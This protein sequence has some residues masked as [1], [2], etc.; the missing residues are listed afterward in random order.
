MS[1]F[2]RRRWQHDRLASIIAPPFFFS[3]IF[4]SFTSFKQWVL[5]NA[6]FGAD[7]L[8][9]MLDRALF[10]GIDPWRITHSLFPG[11]AGSLVFDTAY[12]LWF[13][14]LV[15][16]VLFS[17]MAPLKLRTQFLLSFSL[18]WVFLGTLLAYFLPGAGPCYYEVFHGGSDFA[19]LMA[20]IH[21]HDTA[22]QKAGAAG[23]LA[24]RGQEE[25]LTAFQTGELMIAGGISAMP[26]LHNAIAVLFACA[27][28]AV[29]RVVGVAM[30]LFA[31]IIW[32][33]SVHLGWH[34]AIDGL[35]GGGAAILIWRG[36]GSWATRLTAEPAIA[37]AG[38]PLSGSSQPAHP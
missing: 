20:Q 6:G 24:L 26:S 4:A 25:L 18:I 11:P 37:D 3:L 36:T 2:I 30:S 10:F 12:A 31:A 38:P 35:L 8:F 22:L 7:P 17:W 34:Y 15:L 33:G 32:L 5:P 19:P 23:I 14:P 13:A 16:S 1:D 9:A 29:N 21:A 28:F 27:G